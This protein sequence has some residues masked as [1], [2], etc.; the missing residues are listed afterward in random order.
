MIFK[1]IL[2]FS[3]GLMISCNSSKKEYQIVGNRKIVDSITSIYGNS[4]ALMSCLRC[5]CFID[6]YNKIYYEN[7]TI[8]LGYILLTDTSCNRMNFAVQHIGSS[9]VERISEEFFNV[10]FLRK[11]NGEYEFK[12]L[13]VEESKKLQEIAKSFFE[14]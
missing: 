10:V 9:V 12:I 14:E 5:E 4:L 1:G 2:F 8:N 7:S 6:E 13:T 11:R 3:F